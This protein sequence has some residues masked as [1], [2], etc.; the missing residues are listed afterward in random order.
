MLRSND[1]NI[2]RIALKSCE[3]EQGLEGNPGARFKIYNN[4]KNS[5]TSTISD[6]MKTKHSDDWTKECQ[7]MGIEAKPKQVSKSS[8]DD[9]QAEEFTLDGMMHYLLMWIAADDQVCIV[10]S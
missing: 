9:V 5:Q 3:S 1:S 8:A 10:L 4:M 6:H 2:R 7:D